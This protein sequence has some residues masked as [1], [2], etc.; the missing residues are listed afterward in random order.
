MS[1]STVEID[2]VPSPCISICRMNE[3]SALCEG[4]WRTLDEIAYWSVLDEDDKRA[5][6]LELGQRRQRADA[7]PQAPVQRLGNALP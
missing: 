2:P 5:V 7:V 4:C 6:W 3:A 1:V